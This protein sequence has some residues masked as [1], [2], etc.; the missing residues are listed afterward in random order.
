ML[1][2]SISARPAVDAAD[3]TPVELVGVLRKPEVG[4]R[5]SPPNTPGRWY[6]RDVTAMATVLKAPRPAPLVI[7]AETATNPDWKGL[8]PA[9]I[10]ADIPNRHLEYALTW[11]GL[12]AA[13]LGV[14]A[15][16]LFRRR[17]S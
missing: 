11:Y 7:M 10:P 12:A 8:I 4:N 16:M 17:A 15:A 1:F 14:Y 2:R 5:F 9:P 6:T 3:I 13:L